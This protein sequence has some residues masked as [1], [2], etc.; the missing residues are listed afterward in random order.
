MR[1]AA[2]PC[3]STPDVPLPASATRRSHSRTTAR[4]SF[5][6][7][8]PTMRPGTP[9]PTVIATMDL[10]TGRVVELTVHGVGRKRGARLV[11]RREADR[12]LPVRRKRQQRSGRPRLSAVWLVDADGQNLHQVSPTTL[13]AGYPEWS[14]DGA[15]ILFVSPDREQQDLYTIRPD[16]TDAAS[17]DHGRCLD[18]RDL[19]RGRTDPLRPGLGRRRNWRLCG[20][21]TMDADGTNAASLVSG[22]RGRRR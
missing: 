16:G 8:S 10:A 21:W 11:A 4:A 14:P 6:S 22:R 9:G 13:A 5:S 15:R 20:W 19:A 18:L 2:I 12:L 17:P 3:P 7:A 1:T